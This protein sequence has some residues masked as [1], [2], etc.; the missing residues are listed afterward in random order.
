MLRFAP[1]PTGYLHVGNARIAL[2]NFFYSKK[3][4]RDFIIRFDDTDQDRCEKKFINSIFDD[5]LWLNIEFKRTFNQFDRLNIY[6]DISESLKK[7]EKIYPCYETPEELQLKRKLQLKMGK[8]PIYDRNSLGL[9]DKEKNILKKEGRKPHW[10]FK[11]ENIKIAWNDLVHGEISFDKLSISDP[12]VI[13]SDNTPLFTLTSV[14][15]DIEYKISDILRG[16]DHITNTAAQIQIFEALNARVPNFGHFPLIKNKSGESLSKRK[17]SFSLNQMKKNKIQ[18]TVLINLLL[19]MGTSLQYD[20]IQDID[21]LIGE[22]KINN[23]SKS[24]IIFNEEDLSRMNSKFISSLDFKTLNKHLGKNLEKNVWEVIKFN[25][26]KI[27]DIDNWLKILDRSFSASSELKNKKLFDFAVDCL[28]IEVT[29]NT[30][31]EWCEEISINTNLK[32]KSLFLPLRLKLTG[33]DKGPEMNLILPLLGRDE[34][35]RRLKI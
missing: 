14:I 5:L 29:K 9:S 7:E 25:I 17:N 28:P 13:R 23:Y 12:V 22:F 6:K 24:S 2:L 32:G 27:E 20:K 21:E 11:L 30:W 3:I 1:S 34:I 10:R 33:I 16:D 15:D 4:N 31:R 18:P 26:S 35:I 19:K 8:P